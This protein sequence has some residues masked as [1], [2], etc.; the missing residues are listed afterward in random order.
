MALE[1]KVPI[2]ELGPCDVHVGRGIDL[3]KIHW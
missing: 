1:A 3:Y 2:N